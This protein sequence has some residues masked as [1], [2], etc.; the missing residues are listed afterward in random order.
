MENQTG[1]RWNFI[2]DNDDNA[3]SASRTIDD[4]HS[5]CS[6]C[7]VVG[8]DKGGLCWKMQSWQMPGIKCNV[9]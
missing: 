7:Q 6:H 9:H 1:A 2:L 3:T 4:F 8:Y 5:S